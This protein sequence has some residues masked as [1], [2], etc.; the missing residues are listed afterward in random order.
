[1]ERVYE[2]CGLIHAKFENESC[3][4]DKLGWPRQRLNK[5]TTGRKE[6]N[7]NEVSEIAAGLQEPFE[8]IANIFLS[9]SHQMGNL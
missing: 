5:I 8:K 4:A 3:F 2:L 7:L 9:R 6:P 1:M